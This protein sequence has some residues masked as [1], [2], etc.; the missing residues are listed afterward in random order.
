MVKD[1]TG[2]HSKINIALFKEAMTIF[3]RSDLVLRRVNESYD[4]YGQLSDRSTSDQTFTG[5][6]QFGPDLD[7]KWISTGIIEVGD[8]ILYIA[9]DAISPL[10][11]PGDIIVDI[12]YASEFEVF[13]RIEAPTLGG[14]RVHFSYRC[15]RM[16]ASGDNNS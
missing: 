15:R 4:D 2:K 3:G 13:G 6:L 7:Q 5:D 11:S 14:D 1:R 16:I 12:A 10:P 9:P 8:A